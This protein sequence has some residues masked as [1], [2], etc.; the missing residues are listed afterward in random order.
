MK[1]RDARGI[2]ET[3]SI[4][5]AA[6][7]VVAISIAVLTFVSSS[8]NVTRQQEAQ[9]LNK[10]MLVLKSVIGYGLWQGI[11]RPHRDRGA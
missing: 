7:F 4:A 1:R 9:S 10:E 5:I 11:Q 2:S 8:A 6:A 3:V